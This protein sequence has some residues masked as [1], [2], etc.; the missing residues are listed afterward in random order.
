MSGSS[1]AAE[2]AGSGS[3]RSAVERLERWGRARGWIGPDPYEALNSPLGR[4]LRG[5]RPQQ[6]LI[7]LN[8]RSRWPL[9]PPLRPAPE[10]NAKALALA[11]SA[12]SSEHGSSLPG[13]GTAPELVA[14]LRRLAIHAPPGV[15]WGYHFDVRTRAIFY[16]RRTPNAIA[17][18]FVVEALL[19]AGDQKLALAA[20]PFLRSLAGEGPG[21]RYFAYVP[22]GSK[23]V[24]NANL[25]V[26]G[27]L[28]RL[29]PIEA[30]EEARAI[31]V[32]CA[33]T[34]LRAQPADGIWFYGEDPAYGW[35]DSFHTAYCIDA[36]RALEASY[37][38][39]REQLEL[40]RSGWI[41]RF[42]E[43]DGAAR[44]HPDRRFPLE[45]HSYASAID[46]LAAGD[47]GERLLARRVAASALEQLWLERPGRFAHRRTRIGL[48][49]R[50]FMRWT[51]AP[52]FRALC[53]LLSRSH[54]AEPGAGSG[55]A[56]PPG[57]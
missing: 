49:R 23:L 3:V 35:R 22:T 56:Q 12:Y 8:K 40:A 27:T 43:P 37:G 39:G 13:A 21:G 47:E 9:P 55:P 51:N 6:A 45:A 38:I 11:L 54:P 26:A 53:R 42:F 5:F 52:M 17:T 30:D 28:A 18:C 16:D 25:M 44:L 2:G 15:A 57:Q 1:V 33:E 36:L 32:E 46:T 41:N 48:N 20:R 50:E 19:D 10:P 29:E 14:T 31:A 4:R 34:S 24:H 7:Q